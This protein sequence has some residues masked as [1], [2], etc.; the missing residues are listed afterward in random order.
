MWWRSHP[1]HHRST[2]SRL[3][4]MFHQQNHLLCLWFYP[5]NNFFF[6]HKWFCVVSLAGC[7]FCLICPRAAAVRPL[8]PDCRPDQASDRPILPQPVPAPG[9]AACYEYMLA[10]QELCDALWK[11]TADITWFT[12]FTCWGQQRQVRLHW[13]IQDVLRPQ[14]VKCKPVEQERVITTIIF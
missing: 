6:Q 8:A 10:V 11:K 12:F 7:L 2:E 5:Q 4:H 3:G 1:H 14:M 9:A 13:Y